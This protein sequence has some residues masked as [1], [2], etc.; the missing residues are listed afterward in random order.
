[1]IIKELV[2]KSLLI[3]FLLSV[4][5]IEQGC[6]TMERL[7]DRLKTVTVNIENM[8]DQNGIQKQD[9]Q[10]TLEETMEEDSL[11]TKKE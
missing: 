11:S 8:E 5:C 7:I 3:V 9:Q 1:M 6:S 4:L 2:F 10:T